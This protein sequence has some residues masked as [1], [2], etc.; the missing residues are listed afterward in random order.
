MTFE[1][2]SAY[3]IRAKMISAYNHL[4]HFAMGRISELEESIVNLNTDTNKSNFGIYFG[5]DP[6]EYIGDLNEKL[7]LVKKGDYDKASLIKY[8]EDKIRELDAFSYLGG[9]KF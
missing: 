6:K 1:K 9:R 4:R 3:C 7:S 8:F 5:I 2:F